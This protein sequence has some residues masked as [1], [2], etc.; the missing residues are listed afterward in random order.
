MKTL[1]D[2]LNVHR[3]IPNYTCFHQC[4]CNVMRAPQKFVL[5]DQTLQFLICLN[6]NFSIVKTQVMLMD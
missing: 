1:W 2:E 6:E 3:P 5:E 4:R